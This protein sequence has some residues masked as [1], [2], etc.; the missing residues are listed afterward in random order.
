MQVLMPNGVAPTFHTSG[1]A[2]PRAQIGF[3]NS[4]PTASL[5]QNQPVKNVNGVIVP[6]ATATD[7]VLG[8]FVGLQYVDQNGLV[9]ERNHVLAGTPFFASGGAIN[10]GDPYTN[11]GEAYLYQDPQMEFAVQGNGPIQ[12]SAV[13]QSFSLDPTTLAGG[14]YIGISTALL[15]AVAGPVPGLAGQFIVTDLVQVPGNTWGDPY[16]VVKVKFNNIL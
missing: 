8:I 5:F 9:K 14:T 13:G 11:M 16:T 12:K 7:V 2:N 10:N 15:D 6:I 4:A 3:V 1:T